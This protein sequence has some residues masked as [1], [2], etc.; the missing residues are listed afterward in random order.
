MTNALITQKLT[1]G[2]PKPHLKTLL[3]TISERCK[4]RANFITSKR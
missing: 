2:V 1:G 3:L 4:K